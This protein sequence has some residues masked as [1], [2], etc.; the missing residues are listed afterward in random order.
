MWDILKWQNTERRLVGVG[1]LRDLGNH[2]GREPGR[3]EV[4]S[5]RASST[6]ATVRVALRLF[7]YNQRSFSR[8]CASA[9]FDW[10]AGSV[11][12]GRQRC[13]GQGASPR[14]VET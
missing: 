13:R 10:T 14:N 2:R 8:A 7:R 3:K 1:C 11:G 6:E 5:P 12:T 9:P 4:G